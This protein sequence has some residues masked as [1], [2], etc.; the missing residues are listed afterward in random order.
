[1]SV[2]FRIGLI[3]A[4]IAVSAAIADDDN[5]R[6]ETTHPEVFPDWISPFITAIEAPYIRVSIVQQSKSAYV[7]E[8]TRSGDLTFRHISRKNEG[9][10]TL[11]LLTRKHI[12]AT[13]TR[14]LFV[15][16]GNSKVRHP[17]A[18]LSELQ[19]AELEGFDGAFWFIEVSDRTKTFGTL[20]SPGYTSRNSA[21]V[22]ER[23]G[24]ELPDLGPVIK[25]VDLLLQ[26]A[27]RSL[28]N[29]DY[30]SAPE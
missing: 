6:G 11:T 24:F 12:D 28:E 22:E 1:M 3:I 10:P 29:G 9:D 27:G 14:E 7:V 18:Q 16:F 8:L 17:Y 2:S 13:E 4:A 23:L 30:V 20:W 25:S 15:L 5:H 19:R 21:L 26:L